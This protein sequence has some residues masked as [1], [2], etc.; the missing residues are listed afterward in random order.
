[1]D[2]MF[3]EYILVDTWF[4]MVGEIGKIVEVWG[5]LS[6]LLLLT[7]S[8]VSEVLACPSLFVL[9]H[10]HTQ[11]TPQQTTSPITTTAK[12][13]DTSIITMM[14]DVWWWLENNNKYCA[15]HICSEWNIY[16]GRTI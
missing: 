8:D 2:W 4:V 1:M 10:L 12:T 9:A 13:T 6:G 11:I 5:V 16:V 3:Y 14:S 7:A 15:S